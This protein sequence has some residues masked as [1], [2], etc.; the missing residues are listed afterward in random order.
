MAWQREAAA[1]LYRGQRRF[2]E[3]YPSYTVG[4]GTYGV[5][6]VHDWDEGT[7]LRIGA[8]TSIADD[9]HIFLGG[10]HRIDWVTSFPF[11][12]FLE[13][14]SLISD[15]GGTRGDVLIGN[16]VWLASGSTILSGVTIGDGAVVAARSVVT[17]NVPPTQWLREI[18]TGLSDS[19]S[20]RISVTPYWHVLGGRGPSLKSDTLFHYYAPKT[21][22]D[23]WSTPEQE[24]L[25]PDW[26]K[27]VTNQARQR[28][29][30]PSA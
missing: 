9:V 30:I 10:Q 26:H 4:V 20:R 27:Q 2:G 23:S 14:G 25:G 7:T 8:Y 17:R 29:A 5:P 6:I 3:K 21:F 28:P 22:R 12:A 1:P 15:F 11:P 13:E 18:Q 19:A 24:S 16:D